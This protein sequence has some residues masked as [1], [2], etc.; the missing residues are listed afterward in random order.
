MKPFRK[1]VWNALKLGLVLTLV[2]FLFDLHDPLNAS[3]LISLDILPDF[4]SGVFGTL[5]AL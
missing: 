5:S 2:H 3:V 4:C 1:Y